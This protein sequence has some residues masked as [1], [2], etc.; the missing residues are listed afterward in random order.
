MTLS[1]TT[2]VLVAGFMAANLMGCAGT[3]TAM[4]QD[5]SD[6][7]DSANAKKD[8]LFVPDTKQEI[9]DL[10]GTTLSAVEA[11][12]VNCKKVNQEVAA[13]RTSPIYQLENKT[14]KLACE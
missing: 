4:K 9:A 7:Y 14:Y 6:F 12:D 11:F 3:L 10:T 8:E 2:K 5:A 1:N 13:E